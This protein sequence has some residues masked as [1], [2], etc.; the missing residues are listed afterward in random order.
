MVGLALSKL[1]VQEHRAFDARARVA[2]AQ[3][4]RERCMLQMCSELSR[5]HR[6]L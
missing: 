3:G 5:P 6:P 2:E 1:I 4:M